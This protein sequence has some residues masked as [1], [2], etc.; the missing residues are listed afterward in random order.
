M[1]LSVW[2]R[3]LLSKKACLESLDR[4]T[5]L[6][7]ISLVTASA[8]PFLHVSSRHSFRYLC[9]EFLITSTNTSMDSSWPNLN[10]FL[11]LKRWA[12]TAPAEA[13]SFSWRLPHS[14]PLKSFSVTSW[15]L[16]S[17]WCL[18][19]NT[20]CQNP[21][22]MLRC[23]PFC[24]VPLWLVLR[25]FLPPYICPKNTYWVGEWTNGRNQM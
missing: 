20:S 23:C 1:W 16:C 4:H 18:R 17:W 2:C 8:I 25:Q 15:S 6:I 10:I 12:L 7:V 22:I 11:S 14:L 13:K 5:R 3:M 21:V 24:P 19:S 9:L